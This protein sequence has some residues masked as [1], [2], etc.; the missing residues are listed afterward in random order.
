MDVCHNEIRGVEIGPKTA[1]F[2]CHMTDT[3]LIKEKT[4]KNRNIFFLR[5][6]PIGLYLRMPS[7]HKWTLLLS[8]ATYDSITHWFMVD[9]FVN[10]FHFCPYQAL[11]LSTQIM[12]Y[13]QKHCSQVNL[14][15]GYG[16]WILVKNTFCYQSILYA[17]PYY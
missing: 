16:W 1:S 2:C 5:C 10:N 15:V 4:L 17:I 9:G 6:S 7:T 13:T 11:Q 3:M 14:I 8:G 12:Y